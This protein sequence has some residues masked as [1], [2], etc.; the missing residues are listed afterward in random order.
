ML[1]FV[2]RCNHAHVFYWSTG[3][4]IGKFAGSK[5]PFF[6][7]T[8]SSI[9][10]FFIRLNFFLIHSDYCL[11]ADITFA[12]SSFLCSFQLQQKIKE[13]NEELSKEQSEKLAMESR[14]REEVTSEFTELF[15]NM[16]KDYK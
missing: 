6:I 10:S 15:S 7:H 13:L 4:I 3:S 8:A 16:E 2:D 12:L 14:I 1:C 5:S 11:I 9:K